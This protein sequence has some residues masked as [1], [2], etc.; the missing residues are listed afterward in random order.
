MKENIREPNKLKWN[1]TICGDWILIFDG[2]NDLKIEQSCVMSYNC[3]EWGEITSKNDL[4]SISSPIKNDNTLTPDLNFSFK[5]TQSDKI[6]NSHSNLHTSNYIKKTT[7]NSRNSLTASL[8]KNSTN[9]QELNENKTED[10]TPTSKRSDINKFQ[11]DYS[12]NKISLTQTEEEDWKLHKEKLK[13]FWI[14]WAIPLCVMCTHYES[15]HEGH[16]VKPIPLVLDLAEKERNQLLQEGQ[17][18]KNLLQN[19]ISQYQQLQES[20]TRQKFLY[21]QKLDAEF[22]LILKLVDLRK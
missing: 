11:F 14:N 2:I 7:T 19:S 6:T 16:K 20:M 3:P 8:S 10:I 4:I 12:G 17:D 22:E 15:T 13:L 9:R 1:H 18:I 5:D 21:I